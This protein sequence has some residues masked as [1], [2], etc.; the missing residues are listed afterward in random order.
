MPAALDGAVGKLQGVGCRV[1]SGNL[2]LHAHAVS[3]LKSMAKVACN[4]FDKKMYRHGPGVSTGFCG[5][6]HV[7]DTENMDRPMNLLLGVIALV[8]DLIGIVTFIVSGQVS[9]FWSA[10]WL[11]M[12]VSIGLLLAIALFFLDSAGDQPK[13]KFLP[14]VS[15]AYALLSCLGILSGLYILSANQTT[16]GSFLG[17]G[18]LIVFPA[19]MA[20]FTSEV[21]Y[22]AA[23]RPISYLYATTGLL[24][25]IG[26]MFRYMQNLGFSWAIAGELLILAAIGVGFVTF[27]ENI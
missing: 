24:A 26:L 6:H 17:I 25:I 14:L 20:L 1:W 8:A 13:T 16:F 22:K 5:L 4:D 2:Y 12:L 19:A 18:V 9:Q 27:S 11:V 21:S 23:H 10:T 7:R 15:G 3:D